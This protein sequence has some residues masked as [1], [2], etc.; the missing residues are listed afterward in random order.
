M[1]SAGDWAPG[2]VQLNGLFFVSFSCILIFFY[3]F[4]FN[5]FLDGEFELFMNTSVRGL[6]SHFYSFVEIKLS[7]CF[8]FRNVMY[9]PIKR[10]Y[11]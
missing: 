9:K 4:N 2:G 8:E 5:Y 10:L 11:L 1:A 6:L 7:N 3:F